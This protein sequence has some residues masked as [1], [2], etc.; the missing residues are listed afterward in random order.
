MDSCQ[1]LHFRPEKELQ[2]ESVFWVRAGT[3]AAIGVK[4]K[5]CAGAINIQRELLKFLE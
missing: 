3:R 4:V 2:S 5:V 1:S